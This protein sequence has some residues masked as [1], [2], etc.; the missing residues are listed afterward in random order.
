MHLA[1][2]DLLGNPFIGVFCASNNEVTLVPPQT[3]EGFTSLV[4]EILGTRVVKTT[5][6]SS[7]LLGIFS[8]SNR[9]GIVLPETVYDDEVKKIR[10]YF[11]RVGIVKGFTAV[12]NLISC[13]D[14]GGIASPIISKE[15][16]KEIKMLCATEFLSI[17]KTDKA[18]KIFNE[19]EPKD[20]DVYNGI[21]IC[22]RKE[23]DNEKAI[24]YFNKA[25]EYGDIEIPLINICEIYE[26]NE[27]YESADHHAKYY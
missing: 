20:A 12:G 13:N 1:K 6:C 2:K 7:P 22:Y 14:R 5:L 8:V 17:D 19:I 26:E 10:K 4:R 3:P 9:N 16:I 24:E 23:G 25:I 15:D 21:G 27:E 11:N 18:K